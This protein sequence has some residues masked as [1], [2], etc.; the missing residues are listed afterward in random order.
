[1]WVYPGPEQIPIFILEE[2][3]LDENLTNSNQSSGLLILLREH[4]LASGSLG[5]AIIFFVNS[6]WCVSNLPTSLQRYQLPQ[7]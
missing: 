3:P 4:L 1:M 2:H 6:D 5:K 7:N